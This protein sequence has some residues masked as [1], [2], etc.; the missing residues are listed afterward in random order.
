M[1]PNLPHKLQSYISD[2]D[3]RFVVDNCKNYTSSDRLVYTLGAALQS[4]ITI[5]VINSFL[6]MYN[7]SKEIPEFANEFVQSQN[8]TLY[9]YGFLSL[10]L[11]VRV[12]KDL[13]KLFRLYTFPQKFFVGTSEELIV[14]DFG[15][16]I[17]VNWSEIESVSQDNAAGRAWLYINRRFTFLKFRGFD[18]S[19]DRSVFIM[20]DVNDIGY[21]KQQIEDLIKTHAG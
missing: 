19:R 10:Y 13:F 21:V 5:F 12:I 16:I 1:Y 11:L 6:R 17:R 18:K 2:K 3:V 7:A 14:W 15:N 20:K 9:I 4:F 8:A